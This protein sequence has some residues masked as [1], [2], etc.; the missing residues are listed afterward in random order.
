MPVYRMRIPASVC[1]SIAAEDEEA[2]AKR[3][4]ELVEQWQEG[5]EID[6]GIES[7]RDPAAALYI[8]EKLPADE[9]DIEDYEDDDDD[10]DD[11]EGFDD[12]M[13]RIAVFV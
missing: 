2:A 1:V 6:L 7:E 12:H 10:D 8:H 9:I 11:E 3:C 13:K 4:R 5:I